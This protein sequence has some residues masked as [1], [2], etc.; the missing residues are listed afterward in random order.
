LVSFI[1]K[2]ITIVFIV[3]VKIIIIVVW[4]QEQMFFKGFPMQLFT[5]NCLAEFSINDLSANYHGKSITLLIFWV[6]PV[7]NSIAFSNS[8]SS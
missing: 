7:D 5:A 8:V 2:N 3:I 1:I 6:K 4:G